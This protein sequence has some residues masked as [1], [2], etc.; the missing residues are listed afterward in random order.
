MF[1]YIENLFNVLNSNPILYAI[2]GSTI[3]GGLVFTLRN[4]P[5]KILKFIL[6]VLTINIEVTNATD[7]VAYMSIENDL[8]HRKMYYLA[9]NFQLVYAWLSKRIYLTCAK[10]T[11]FITRIN[12]I[13]CIITKD[14]SS[15]NQL[16]HF[17]YYNLRFFTRDKEK[18][19]KYIATLANREETITS[20]DSIKIHKYISRSWEYFEKLKVDFNCIQSNKIE[21]LISRI[22]KLINNNRCD[23]LGVLLYGE[24]GCGKTYFVQMLAH[25]LDRN[26]YYV[27]MSEFGSDNEFISTMLQVKHPSI[28]L[29]EDIDCHDGIN[30][31]SNYKDIIKKDKEKNK[32]V[33]LS[34]ILNVFDGLLAQKDQFIIATTNHIENLDKALIRSGRFDIC[35]EVSKLDKKDIG[36]FLSNYYGK[37]VDKIDKELNSIAVSDLVKLC[38]ENNDYGSVIKELP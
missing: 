14:T 17:Y 37:R 15:Q 33:S 4:L 22:F 35:E 7:D 9:G 1:E 5:S 11:Y 27:N 21:D 29:F 10:S 23:K 20:E 34:C 13:L 28:I 2:F 36:L 38:K 19:Y 16:Q 25:V 6:S 3:I 32:G 26:I 12:G 18:V 30:R 31:E 24:P 8:S